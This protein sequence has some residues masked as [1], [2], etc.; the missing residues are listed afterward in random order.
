MWKLK[1]QN[2][3][4]AESLS[5]AL[6]LSLA[7]ARV[8]AARGTLEPGAARRFLYPQLKD[9]VSVWQLP[10]IEPAVDRLASA[11]R[12]REPIL[13]WGHEDLD[14]MTSAVCLRSTLRDLH[15]VVTSF[16]PA[17]GAERHGLSVE[18]IKGYSNQGIRLV[19]TVDCGVTNVDEVEE[20]QR[21]GIDVIITDHHEVLENLPAARAVVNPKREDRSYP[22][23]YLAGV[24][25]ALK[26]AQ[27]L[28]ER[29]VG[30]RPE[31]FYSV[32]PELL[33][34]AAL[35]GIADR[36][37]MLGENR[38]LIRHGLDRLRR[39]PLPSI[40]AVLE[41]AGVRLEEL[42]VSRFVTELLPLFA[43]ADGNKG[44]EMLLN[45]DLNATRGWAKELADQ[46]RTWRVEAHA[47]LERARQDMD[48]SPGL[49]VVRNETLSLRALGYC[50]ARI[51]D[52]YLLPVMV[53]GRRE[54]DWVG[55]CRGVS[56]VN[57]VA[58]LKT[59]ARYFLDYG[60]HAKACGFT[61]PD[62]HVTA[63]IRDAKAY[64]AANFQG[65]ITET[66]EPIADAEVGLTEINDDLRLIGPIGEGN[67]EVLLI[68]RSER[69][70]RKADHIQAPA[71][72][73]LVIR[74][75]GVRL[76]Q[77]GDYDV[78]YGLDEELVV[79]LHELQPASGC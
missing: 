11:V 43:S 34:M 1:P 12:R 58:L 49:I 29:M 61:V 41:A 70:E 35:G 62:E 59:N 65:R 17:K 5:R 72:H 39:V 4:A 23:P 26:V 20:I 44:V 13:I 76:A 19:V 8:L 27:A 18:R 50:A 6:N 54:N 24:G 42:T 16:I 14:G 71:A 21:D 28:A 47:T 56:G 40:Q 60:G 78:L 48:I 46:C 67:P 31:E 69:L 53:I 75:N 36:V 38:I 3:S 74:E 37:P 32:E 30:T 45:P 77:P 63:F 33:V 66:R 73:A 57:L 15:G 55:E 51:K 52:E 79:T 9:L 2:E 22:F 7:L 10:D 64:A 68:A 25:V